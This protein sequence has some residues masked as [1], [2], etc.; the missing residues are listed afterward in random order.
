MVKRKETKELHVFTWTDDEVELLLKV[1]NEYKVAKAAKTID[2]ESV[3]L[4]YKEILE[5]FTAEMERAKGTAKD[6]PHNVR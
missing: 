6:Y 3:H 5:R 1:T 2:W 4:K